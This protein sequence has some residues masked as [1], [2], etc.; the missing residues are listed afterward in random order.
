MKLRK[1]FCMFSPQINWARAASPLG[2]VDSLPRRCQIRRA[3]SSRYDWLSENESCDQVDRIVSRRFPSRTVIVDSGAI[4]SEVARVLH[5]KID[6]LLGPPRSIQNVAITLRASVSGSRNCGLSKQQWVSGSG[7]VK[8][9]S[10][11]GKFS[12]EMVFDVCL[13]GV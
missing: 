12:T 11:P 9:S 8:Q 13:G 10:C 2:S 4:E 7:Y 3:R 5:R 1:S 6:V